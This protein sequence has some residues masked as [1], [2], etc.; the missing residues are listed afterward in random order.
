MISSS[1]KMRKK[2]TFIE[3][4]AVSEPCLFDSNLTFFGR[5]YPRDC[6]NF[7][8]A[9]K[10]AKTISSTNRGHRRSMVHSLHTA[11]GDVVLHAPHRVPQHQLPDELDGFERTP[12]LRCHLRPTRGYADDYQFRLGSHG[13]QR[14][15]SGQKSGLR[16]WHNGR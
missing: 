9:P 4:L 2:D 7:A 15:K 6:R 16:G 11:V 13:G 5:L 3:I 1:H 14:R 10:E 8:E 12:G